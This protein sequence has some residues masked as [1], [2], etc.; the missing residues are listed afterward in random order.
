VEADNMSINYRD[1]LF[2][3]YNATHVANVDRDDQ[4]KLAWF[5][6]YAQ[7]NYLPHIAQYDRKQATILDIGCNK[8]YLLT[9]LQGFGFNHLAG[10]D[11]SPVDVEKAKQLMPSIH[12]TCTDAQS[13]LNAHV[14]KYDVIFMKAVLEHIAKADIL[15]LLTQIK[16]GLKTG[17]VALIDVPNMDWLF[18]PHE[19]YMDFTH[20]VGFTKES[21]RQVMLNVFDQV[22]VI[23]VDSITGLRPLGELR[24]RLARYILGKLLL[25]ADS[26]GGSGPLW[27]RSLIAIGTKPVD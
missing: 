3:T 15:P 4:A 2:Q 19:R 7:V 1:R 5:A 13:Y 27:S 24:K 12:F 11:L 8:G 6:E 16:A 22:T 20:E 9:A 21:L 23:P 25:W 17:G 14:G 18:A 10:I 26:Q